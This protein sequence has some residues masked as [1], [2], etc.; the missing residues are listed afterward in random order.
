[1]SGAGIENIA[2]EPLYG[3]VRVPAIFRIQREV[4]DRFGLAPIEMVSGRRSRRV[5]RP[6]QIAMFLCRE[7]TRASLPMIGRHFGNRDHT[8]I[9]HACWTVEKLI[10][11]DSDF[12]AVVAELRQCI[13]EPNQPALLRVTHAQVLAAQYSR[14]AA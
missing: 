9:M 13:S 12:A 10:L 1:V 4:C 7:L 2:D 14:R 3:M 5:A 8:T 11:Q 6:R